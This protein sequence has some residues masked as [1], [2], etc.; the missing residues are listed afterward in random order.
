MQPAPQGSKICFR[1]TG[2]NFNPAIRQI[3]DP[4]DQPQ[5]PRPVTG[6]GTEKHPLYPTRDVTAHDGHDGNGNY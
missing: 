1:A 3:A 2:N 4:T 5:L 6:G